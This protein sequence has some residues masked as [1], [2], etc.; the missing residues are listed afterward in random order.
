MPAKPTAPHPHIA[1]APQPAHAEQPHPDAQEDKIHAKEIHKMDILILIG[2]I[3]GA[4]LVSLLVA[5]IIGHLVGKQLERESKNT[6]SQRWD[7]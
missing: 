3:V 1:N 6:N 7:I 5:S 2:K 4:F